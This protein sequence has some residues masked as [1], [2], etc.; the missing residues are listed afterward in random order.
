MWG[1]TFT[2]SFE[3]N[4]NNN[5]LC[6]FVIT[7]MRG[8]YEKHTNHFIRKCECMNCRNEMMNEKSISRIKKHVLNMYDVHM[9]S[10]HT[11][12]T[13]FSDSQFY[14]YSRAKTTKFEF[15]QQNMFLA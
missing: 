12:K 8:R 4:N 10:K 7:T 11:Q 5:V 9:Y 13:D 1:A 15:F 2:T 14:P 6:H 3:T